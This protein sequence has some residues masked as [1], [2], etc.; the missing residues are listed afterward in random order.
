YDVRSHQRK[1]RRGKDFMTRIR[2]GVGIG[3]AVAG[4]LLS[5][6]GT[7]SASMAMQKKAKDAGFEATNCLYCHQD[8]L[9]KKEA[10]ALNDRGKFLL[11]EK[12]KRKASEI[13]VNWLKD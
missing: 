1:R 10:H 3:L 8:K 5:A 12:D 6:A 4:M 11:A 13:D 7:V 2:V 9:P